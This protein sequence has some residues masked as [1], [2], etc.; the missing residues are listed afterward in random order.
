MKVKILL[1][2]DQRLM[3]E[4]FRALI[5]DQT[6]LE[7]I[8]EAETGKEAIDKALT[9]MPNVVVMDITLRGSEMTGIQATRRIK[10]A[11][12]DIKVLALSQ[13]E[14]GPSIKGMVS[15][16]A[17]GY[18]SKSCTTEELCEAIATVMQG[19]HYFSAEVSS[20][21]Q[22][23]FVHLSQKTVRR[24]PNAL[25]ERETEILRRTTLGENAKSI[26]DALGLSSKTVDAH[27]RNLMK[28]LGITNLADLIKYAL[29]KRIIE[30]GE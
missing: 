18:L 19:R 25:T 27:R 9:L 13:W 8:G 11:R 1:V 29:R 20:A 23:E 10:T 12:P 17:S 2:E 22:D 3:R 7:I 28:K 16:G 14:D 30:D 5:K 4:G 24:E 15:A 21:V 6:N 26:A